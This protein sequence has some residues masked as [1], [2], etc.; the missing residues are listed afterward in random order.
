VVASNRA[1]IPEAL[2]DAALYVDPEKPEELAAGIVRVLADQ[3]LAERLR[4]AGRRRAAE[5]TARMAAQEHLALY[6]EILA[7]RGR[8]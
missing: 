6:A 4:Q 3:A 5:F 7:T 2:G 8:R 1:S